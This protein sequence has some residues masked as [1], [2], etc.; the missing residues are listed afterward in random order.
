MDYI[1]IGFWI[2]TTCGA[3]LIILIIAGS[4]GDMHSGGPC[5][6]KR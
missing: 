2:M 3:G 6:K 5:G 4:G 1:E